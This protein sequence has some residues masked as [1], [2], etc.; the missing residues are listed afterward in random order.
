MTP[1][2]LGSPLVESLA[3]S[4]TRGRL[5]VLAYHGVPDADRFDAQ[6]AHL[7][8]RYRPV[9]GT[10]VAAALHGGAPLPDRAVWVTFDD[11]RPDV[12][13]TG[14]A[15]LRR[16]DVPATLFVCPGLM[17]EDRPMWPD[18]VEAALRADTAPG[19]APDRRLV[20]AMKTAPDPLRRSMVDRMA[21]ELERRGIVVA[22]MVSAGS[23]R[24]WLDAGME[25][26]N[27]TWD[28]P[29]LDRCD[30]EAQADQIRRGHAA[31]T[32]LLGSPPTLFAYPNGDWTAAAEAVLRDLGYALALLFDHRVTSR[33]PDPL[34]ISRLRI[35]ADAPLS[36]ARAILGGTHSGLFHLL[37]R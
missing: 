11:G 26:G 6:V 4:A 25:V 1:S 24:R 5:R 3:A 9:S 12:V 18:V 10:Q 14:L 21:E 17:A 34:R 20:T 2:L 22:P 7:V 35:D 29:C 13:D 19:D 16:H 33:R 31:L 30:A 23:L 37:R 32:E 28:H 15:V 8:R 27:H 36:R